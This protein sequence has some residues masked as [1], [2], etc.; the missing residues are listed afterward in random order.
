MVRS[1]CNLRQGE[2]RAN[3]TATITGVSAYTQS[4]QQNPYVNTYGKNQGKNRGNPIGRTG[5]FP[6]ISEHHISNVHGLSIIG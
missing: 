6:T 2:K 4:L 5:R 3:W 1:V